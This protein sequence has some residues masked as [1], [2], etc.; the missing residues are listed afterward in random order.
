MLTPYQFAS[1]TPIQAIDLDGLEA[2]IVINSPW[3]LEHKILPALKNGDVAE[4]KRL[5]F[6]VLGDP[7]KDDYQKGVFNNEFAASFSID[8]SFTGI[9]VYAPDGQ[10]LFKITAPSTKQGGM[11]NQKRS[12]K[13]SGWFSN[14]KLPDWLSAD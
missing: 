9:A 12:N 2:V 8:R 13:F 11:V 7:A 14:C 4:V 5:L 10:G 3:Y 1:N 6:K